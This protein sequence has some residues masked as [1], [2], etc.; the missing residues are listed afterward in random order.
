MLDV[1]RATSLIIVLVGRIFTVATNEKVK[2]FISNR[3]GVRVR[4][5]V[6]MYGLVPSM[7]V[8]VWMKQNERKYKV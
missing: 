3:D 6:C 1:E 5:C 7:C 2:I 8:C 4:L